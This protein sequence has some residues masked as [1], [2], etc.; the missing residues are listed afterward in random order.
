M[1]LASSVS[2]NRAHALRRLGSRTAA[3]PAPPLTHVCVQ[4]TGEVKSRDAGGAMRSTSSG[5]PL[6]VSPFHA[7]PGGPTSLPLQPAI[8]REL[9][10]VVGDVRN[11][12]A[13][14]HASA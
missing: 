8:V 6:S 14:F 9:P 11:R 1:N 7:L 13:H 3:R 5:G 12:C 4:I 10:P 2:R